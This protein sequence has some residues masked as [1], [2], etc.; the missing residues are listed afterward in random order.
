MGVNISIHEN[1]SGINIKFCF[2]YLAQ[3]MVIWNHE[4]M[5]SRS[6]DSVISRSEY[7]SGLY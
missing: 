6:G 1:T 4:D 3:Y 2:T 7:F 5:F